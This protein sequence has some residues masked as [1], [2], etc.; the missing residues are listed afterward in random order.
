MAPLVKRLTMKGKKGDT[1]HI[2]KPIRGSASSKAESTAVQIQANLE[3]ELIV[4]VDQH[5][6]YSRLIE[7][8]V[9]TQALTSLRKFYTDDAGYALA[10]KVD[11]ILFTLGTGV[12]NGT[13]TATPLAT[14]ASWVNTGTYYS[15]ASTGLTAYAVDTVLPADVFTDASFRNLIQKMDD[16][17]VPMDGRYFVIPPSMRNTMMGIERFV[18]SDFRN[19]QTV[20]SGLIGSIY[21]IDVYVSSNCPVIET[22]AN[23]TVSTVDTR[24]AFL[25]HKEAFVL[26][27][28]MSVRSQTQYK[29][30]YLS[31]L[32]TADT[33]FGVKNYRPE[34]AF[35]LAVP[36]VG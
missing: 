25:F 13:Y 3:T 5:W 1:I 16:N 6:E 2:P 26:A 29:Q 19:D 18:S 35:V 34:A 32:Y 21:G 12:G 20:K 17:D 15:D 27:E 22:A 36:N 9:E 24:G 31:T 14:G 33:L 7:D 30:E 4:S 10:K 28:Q 23:N 11:D 8:I